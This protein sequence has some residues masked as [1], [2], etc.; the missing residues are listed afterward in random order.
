[1]LETQWTSMAVPKVLGVIGMTVIV[2]MLMVAIFLSSIMI[3]V[4]S[5]MTTLEHPS[6]RTFP[7]DVC[8]S[9]CT[10]GK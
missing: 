5:M 4:V 8:I 3:T 10:Y 9:L 2:M 1:M 6:P 7:G